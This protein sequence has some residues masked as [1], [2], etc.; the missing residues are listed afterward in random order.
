MYENVIIICVKIWLPM[1][2]DVKQR[3]N[4]MSKKT[5]AAAATFLR[6]GC[7]PKQRINCILSKCAK[8]SITHFKHIVENVQFYHRLTF[9]DVIHAICV[10]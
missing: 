4:D 2:N 3:K 10:N 9:D 8:Q 1:Y 7:S 6:F 5:N